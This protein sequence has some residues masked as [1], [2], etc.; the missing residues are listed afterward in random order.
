[1]ADFID[2]FSRAICMAALVLIVGLVMAGLS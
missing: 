2:S 1:M